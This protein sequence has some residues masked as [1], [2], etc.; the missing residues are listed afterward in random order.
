MSLPGP[1]PIG[2]T[3]GGGG[4]AT[5]SDNTPEPLG[6]ESAG[7]GTEASRWDHI[8]P[9]PS[10]ADV[11]ALGLTAQA[12]DSAKL[13]GVTPTA[14]GLA[15]LGD[16]DAA[17]QRTTM[18]LGDSATK[19]VGTS[20]GTV[21]SGDDSRLSNA[22]TPT[23]HASSHQNGGSDE[24]ATATP[25]ANAIPKAGAGGTLAAGWLPSATTSAPG[26]VQ[27]DSGGDTAK[28][29]NGNGAWT[30]PAGSRPIEAGFISDSALTNAFLTFSGTTSYATG[31]G[32]G[33]GT[34]RA[35][36][37]VVGRDCTLTAIGLIVNTGAANAKARIGIYESDAAG[38]PGSLL[39]DSGEFDCSTNQR[40]L[41]TGLSV[42][43]SASKVYWVAAIGGTASATFALVSSS[44]VLLNTMTAAASATTG[45]VF[46]AVTVAQAY[47]ALP[48]TFPAGYA[49][50]TSVNI[51]IPLLRVS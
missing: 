5:L 34:L 18:G 14:A 45:S 46:A 4:G 21:A 51:P 1:E 43:L 24:I 28:F 38:G 33:T 23:A 2:P 30:A 8:H 26:A 12:A 44:A 47:G 29:L 17:A 22:R 42:A 11:G 49:A 15:L 39:V 10:A 37:L 20:A 25:G 6:S 9:M 35:R 48:S 19:N 36:P 41:T 13:A 31:T 27:L 50:A 16:A 32:L 40:K 3:G 7:V